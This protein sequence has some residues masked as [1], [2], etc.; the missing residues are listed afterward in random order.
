MDRARKNLIYKITVVTLGIFLLGS[1]WLSSKMASD[2]VS[3]VV[4]PAVPR[5][6]EPVVATF[7]LNNSTHQ[8]L[9]VNYAFYANG[10]LLS[11]GNT[12]ISPLSQKTYQYAY[13]N[14][15]KLGEQVNFVVKAKSAMGTYERAVSTP[16][17]APQIWSSFVSFASFSTSVMSSMSSMVYY[18][19]SFGAD[20]GMNVGT[21]ISLALILLLIFMELSHPILRHNPIATMSRLRI[22]FSTI[23]WIL[24]IVIIG[25]IYTA[26]AAVF[27][28]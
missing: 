21:I 6:G 10:E 9:P 5:E 27:A 19:S 3:L 7:K 18:Q 4:E 14:L 16:Q 22:R 13:E 15:T 20:L 26:V 8:E 28:I 25:I 11:Q 23:S 24:V 17:Y 2:P 1:F 12:V